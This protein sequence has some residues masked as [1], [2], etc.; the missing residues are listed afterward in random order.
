MRYRNSLRPISHRRF[1]TGRRFRS[2]RFTSRA[3]SRERVP[4]RATGP[5]ISRQRPTV[6]AAATA[7]AVVR[8]AVKEVG[9]RTFKSKNAGRN[10]RPRGNWRVA[11]FVA[12]P[13]WCEGGERARRERKG[14]A[15][16]E[17]D[18]KIRAPVKR[19]QVGR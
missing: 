12:S 17:W 7:A 10:S 2:I 19:G 16:G 8:G 6:A 5:S 9:A 14:I 3:S 1:I 4:R 11:E 18:V 15:K 13:T